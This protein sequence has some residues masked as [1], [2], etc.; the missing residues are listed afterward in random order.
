[1]QI[2]TTQGVHNVEEIIAT[3]G[4]DALF[5]GPAD[6]AAQM[7]YPDN[8]SHAEVVAAVD[9]VVSVAVAAG[10]PV[11]VN[12]FSPRD[13]DRVLDAGADFVVTSADVLLSAQ[14]AKEQVAR[15][16]ARDSRS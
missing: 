15:I 12:A 3:D 8:S 16:R 13:A 14:G 4:V 9:H 5:V 11:G 6:L 1:M 2:E 7:G 10:I